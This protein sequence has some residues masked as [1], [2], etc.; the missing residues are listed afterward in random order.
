[1]KQQD[2]T[3]LFVADGSIGG[4]GYSVVSMTKCAVAV[5]SMAAVFYV[6]PASAALWDNA[7]D[8]LDE[9]V[10]AFEDFVA[11]FL[12]LCG[13]VLAWIIGWKSPGLGIATAVAVLVFAAMVGGHEEITNELGFGSG[14]S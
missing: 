9:S 6:E 7:V 14:G 3:G 11:G 1:M 12:V 4:R 13:L 10:V 5:I 2:Q 8:V